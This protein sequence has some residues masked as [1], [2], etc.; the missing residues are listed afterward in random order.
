MASALRHGALPTLHRLIRL[1]VD[2]RR[3]LRSVGLPRLQ[4]RT[5]SAGK[6]KR[7]GERSW[8]GRGSPVDAV[9]LAG[10]RRLAPTGAGDDFCKESRL[11]FVGIGFRFCARCRKDQNPVATSGPQSWAQDSDP[12]RA[13]PTGSESCRHDRAY[14]ASVSICSIGR[15]PRASSSRRSRSSRSAICCVKR[16]FQR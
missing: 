15:A 2:G 16:T 14:S 10:K 4:R 9:V 8:G 13:L 7:H 12:V 5:S 1:G 3:S 11:I 6:V